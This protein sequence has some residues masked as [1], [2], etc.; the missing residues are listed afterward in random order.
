MGTISNSTPFAEIVNKKASEIFQRPYF[1]KTK[2]NHHFFFKNP[3][4]IRSTSVLFRI[5]PTTKS[6]KEDFL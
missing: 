5:H 4:K 6:L 3:F 1:N 2:R